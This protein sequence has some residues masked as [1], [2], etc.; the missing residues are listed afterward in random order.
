MRYDA[1]FLDVDGTLLWVDLDI[2]GYVEDLTP[3][4]T[5]ATLSV[6]E[7][8]GAL[9]ESFQTHISEHMY[10]PTKEQLADFRRENI[11]KTADALGLDVPT[12]VL[13]EVLK[14][15]THFNPYPESEEVMEELT[16]MGL[17]LYVLS[18]WDAA[19]EHV[20]DNLGWTHYFSGIIAS[21]AV[22]SEKPDEEIFREALRVA[23]VPRERVVHVGND[24]ISDIWG[25]A[26]YGIDAVLVDRRGGA[27]AS[28]AVAI[29]PNLKRLPAL[30]KG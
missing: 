24:P 26:S 15:R 10:Y 19:L 3:Y 4:A 6:E 30:V 8:R 22:G 5:N 25:A 27:E 14:K 12:E 9:Q 13:S 16:R 18:N 28:E 29:I 23:G 17:P 7:A 2:E 11:R 21:A 20:L 1:V